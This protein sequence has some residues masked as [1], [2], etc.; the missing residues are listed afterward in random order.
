[1]LADVVAGLDVLSAGTLPLP[2][3]R[4]RGS[5]CATRPSRLGMRMTNGLVAQLLARKRSASVRSRG[6]WIYVRAT[7]CRG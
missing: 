4:N 3:E 5:D 6:A 2:V 1:M 7:Y